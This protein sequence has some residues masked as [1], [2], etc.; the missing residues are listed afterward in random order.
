M[1]TA[2]ILKSR[3]RM[4]YILSSTKWMTKS[5]NFTV[6]DDRIIMRGDKADE[7]IH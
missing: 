6:T 7:N 3:L 4:G 5:K 1:V 2:S